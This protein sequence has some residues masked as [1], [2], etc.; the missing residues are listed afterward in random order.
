MLQEDKGKKHEINSIES[1]TQLLFPFDFF[2]NANMVQI[3]FCLYTTI[4]TQ[5]QSF[6]I[7]HTHRSKQ[8]PIFAQKKESSSQIHHNILENIQSSFKNHKQL[9]IDSN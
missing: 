8:M 3:Q 7:A 5:T 9:M 1:I 4:Y 6:S 2:F